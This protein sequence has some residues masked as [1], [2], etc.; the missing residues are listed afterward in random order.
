MLDRGLQNSA[1]HFATPFGT[2]CEHEEEFF[3]AMEDTKHSIWSLFHARA[4]PHDRPA[5]T[6]RVGMCLASH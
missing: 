3:K 1:K 2:C 5:P 6:T 4:N